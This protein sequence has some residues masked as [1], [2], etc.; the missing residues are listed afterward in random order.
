MNKIIFHIDFDSYFVSAH[1][2]KNPF[3][4]NKPVAIGKKTY[5]S[6]VTSISYE[7]KKLGIKAGD[8]VNLV[9]NK[10]PKTIFIQPDFNL[11]LEISN[12]IFEYLA[13]K[14]SKKIE[15]YSIDECWIDITNNLKNKSAF[16]MAKEIQNNI[17]KFFKIP[18]SIGISYNKFFAKM[19]TTLA[20]PFGIKEINVLNFKEQLWN[21]DLKEYFGIGKA[22]LPKLNQLNIWTIKDL[23]IQNPYNPLLYSI[24]KSKTKILIDQANGTADDVI[25]TN[26]NHPKSIGVDLTFDHYDYD[27]NDLINILKEI[28]N[29]IC[30][31]A[32]KND[33]VSDTIYINFR[34]MD[35]KWKG[36]QY[37]LTTYSNEFNYIFKY[38]SILFEQMYQNQ[39]L[40]GIGVKIL[41]VK[42]IDLV[43]IPI[44]LF[45]KENNNNY[46]NTKINNQK[47]KKIKNIVQ[48]IN[49][50]TNSSVTYLASKLETNSK[51][52]KKQTRF[53]SE[54]SYENTIYKDKKWK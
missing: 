12:N 1:R 19:A 47:T 13:I 23:A 21:L 32:Q 42:D 30:L 39:K 8:P 36:K 6:I 5:K 7:L 26:N 10:E 35:K 4:N 27:K 37:K 11:Y 29:K 48:L 17:M 2:S 46:N 50:K 52:L 25:N 43:S 40:K 45:G 41:N 44:P 20:K 3:L 9:I 53:F 31:K 22:L 16:Q 14:Y 33:L 28:T 34:Y 51:L 18:I 54:N 49:K 24:L 38:V 15:I